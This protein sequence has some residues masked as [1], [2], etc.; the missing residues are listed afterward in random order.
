MLYRVGHLVDDVHGFDADGANPLQQVDDVLFVV[1]KAVGV[2]E[3]ADGGVAGFLF[4]VLVEYPFQGGAVAEFVVPRPSG[5]SGE[6]GVGIEDDVALGF[7][8]FEFGFGGFLG[9]GSL[10]PCPLSR[11]ELLSTHK[12]C[13]IRM[14]PGITGE[15]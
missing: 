4:F 12:S 9:F 11:M 7:V 15:F 1:G 3:F 5:H 10:T 8:G 6:G 2:E 13:C 14:L